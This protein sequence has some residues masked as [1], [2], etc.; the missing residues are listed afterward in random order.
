MNTWPKQA[1]DKQ[2]YRVVEIYFQVI[3]NVTTVTKIFGE[4]SFRLRPPSLF[5]LSC[6]CASLAS[7]LIF[8][9]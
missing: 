1:G 6:F 8:V 9:P 7:G 3:K 2:R 5:H 4:Q